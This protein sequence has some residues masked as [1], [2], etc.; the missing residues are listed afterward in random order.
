MT[1]TVHNCVPEYC[2]KPV[3]V[4]GCGNRLF[5]DDGFGPSVIEYIL[6]TQNPP[7]D[8]CLLDVGT[9]AREVLFDIALSDRR[10]RRII[11]MD[12]MDCGKEPGTLLELD[13]D[14]IPENK[15][16]DFSMHQAPTSNLLRELRDFCRVEVVLV[17]LQPA[18]I[19]QE[20]RPGLSGPAQKALRHA[21]DAVLNKC[22]LEPVE[23]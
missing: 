13:L 20:V 16:D 15:S 2:R 7:G 10:P 14:A 3:L 23:V 4:L 12:A 17:V 9:S 22:T 18:D 21:A 6:G 19:P 5:G 1:E 11:V 8:V